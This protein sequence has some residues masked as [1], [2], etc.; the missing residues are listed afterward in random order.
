MDLA[1]AF[2]EEIKRRPS[3]YAIMPQ[4]DSTRVTFYY[5]PPQ[6]R[7]FPRRTD[8]LNYQMSNISRRI[9]NKLLK[10]GTALLGLAKVR[11]YPECFAVSISNSATTLDDLKYVLDEIEGAANNTAAAMSSN[12]WFAPVV[13]FKK[14]EDGQTSTSTPSITPYATPPP[15]RDTYPPYVN[16]PIESLHQEM[17]LRVAGLFDEK[18]I[19]FQDKREDPLLNFKAPD[20][21]MAEFDLNL[22]DAPSLASND[23]IIGALENMIRYSIHQ[24]HPY[25]IYQL[26]SGGLDAYTIMSDF[27]STVMTTNS[28]TY[29][30]AP[31]YTLMEEEVLRASRRRIGYPENG[32]GMMM[33]G[34]SVCNIVAVTV[35][36]LTKFADTKERGLDG[37]RDVKPTLFVSANAHYCLIKAGL[38][39][40]IGQDNVV[41]VPADPDGRMDTTKL[42]DAIAKSRDDGRTPFFVGATGGT[43]VLG[44]FDNLGEI[45]QICQENNMWMHIDASVG[46][47]AMFSDTKL[48]ELWEN[49][50]LSDSI[51]FN[52]HKWFG[53]SQ[54]TTVLMFKQAGIV[55]QTLG[56][57][58][59]DNRTWAN[60]NNNYDSNKAF[61]DLAAHGGIGWERRPNVLKLWMLWKAKGRVGMGNHIDYTYANKD[62]LMNELRK[63][64]R[65]EMFRLVKPE[66]QCAGVCFYYIPKMLRGMD[67]DS[68]NYKLAIEQVALPLQMRLVRAGVTI[69]P[70]FRDNGSPLFTKFTILSSGITTDDIAYLLD[71]IDYYG[72]DI[73]VNMN[74]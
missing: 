45:A 63:P 22:T 52:P 37:W 69:T 71:A 13:P 43:T 64:E 32:D 4:L 60:G 20:D 55:K 25:Y 17:F 3:F 73:R 21:L 51:S 30:E 8:Y 41:L 54:E 6:F 29:E 35:A 7:L 2:N 27:I 74:Q 48:A 61:G 12:P 31:I 57:Q 39:N 34:G 72:Q 42:R 58:Q 5:V 14:T 68:A 16:A 49:G 28:L 46:G 26:L 40:G 66:Y 11:A 56:L 10:D 38:L 44:V 19:Y 70:V 65:Q 62:F 9:K 53:S 36:R 50:K 59:S 23:E 33:P 24:A 67:E 47:A 1:A 18:G 15:P